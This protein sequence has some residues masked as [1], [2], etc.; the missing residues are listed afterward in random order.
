MD[1]QNSTQSKTSSIVILQ[2]LAAIV[3]M[4]C[5]IL[6][7]IALPESEHGRESTSKDYIPV[8]IWVLV[9]FSQLAVL[10][11]FSK[12]IQYLEIIANKKGA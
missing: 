5:I 10:M 8:A 4:V 2:Y 6:A 11:A 7:F 12:L 1:K 3:W 9:G